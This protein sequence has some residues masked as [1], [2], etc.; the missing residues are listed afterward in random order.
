M[1]IGGQNEYRDTQC[2][3]KK[4]VFESETLRGKSEG[5]KQSTGLARYRRKGKNVK[6]NPGAHCF[7]ICL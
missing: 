4:N 6:S 7:W 1:K 2:L 3:R 5:C